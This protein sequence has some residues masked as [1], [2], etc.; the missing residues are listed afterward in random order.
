MEATLYDR[1]VPVLGLLVMMGISLLMSTDWRAAL[2]RWP[3]IA[4]GVGLQFLLAIIVLKTE[5]GTWIFGVLDGGFNEL[6]NCTNAGSEF[7][8]GALGHPGGPAS[9]A[10]VGYV[11][12]KVAGVK[13]VTNFGFV[14][15][16]FVLP[17][18]IF[19]SALTSILFHLNIMQVVVKGI[20]WVMQRTLKTSGAETLSTSANIFLGQTEAPLVVKPYIARMTNSELMAIMVGGFATVAGGVMAAYVG[21]LHDKI[22]H[23]AGH[24]MAASVMAAPGTLLFSKLMVPET[25][26]PETSG[27]TEIKI[28]KLSAN[29]V[30][31]A[32]LGASEGVALSLNVGGMLIA[33][34]A[35]I[36]LLDMLLQGST[37]L[38]LRTVNFYLNGSLADTAA[39]AWM[40]LRTLA[41]YLFAPQAWLLGVT[42]PAEA[43][44]VGQLL[45]VKMVSNEFVAYLEMANMPDLSPRAR[46]I[47]AYALCG[48][49][50]FGSIGIQIGG[51]AVMAP[52][53]RQDISRLALRA[54]IAGTFA[55]NATGA[56]AAILM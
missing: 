45:G 40:N 34:L 41:G 30:D 48:F 26:V 28:E 8:F 15:A 24:L 35:V 20:A 9:F 17:S 43:V 36:A 38:V 54:M 37:G 42:N 51:L 18:I 55:S 3:L 5:F 50:N 12:G 31:A 49:A 53:R 32:T 1:L 4:W 11:D 10:T 39:P 52:E 16:F 14:F 7:V 27:A 13:D 19:F 2:K 33:F 29:V 21:F 56:I 22:P 25:E 44:K 23:I 46:V 47:A 6:I